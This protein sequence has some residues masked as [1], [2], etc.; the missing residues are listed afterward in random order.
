MSSRGKQSSGQPNLSE[1]LHASQR[2][3]GA[4]FPGKPYLNQPMPQSN[5]A[6]KRSLIEIFDEFTQV[7]SGELKSMNLEQ[8][9]AEQ[10]KRHS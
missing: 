1:T 5:L 6:V 10:K 3:L 2:D 8:A 7:I 4:V 9:Q